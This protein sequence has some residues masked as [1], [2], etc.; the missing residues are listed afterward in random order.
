MRRSNKG[1]YDQ[2]EKSERM[3]KTMW[4][5]D[6]RAYPTPE[7]TSQRV[8]YSSKDLIPN[9]SLLPPFPL[10]K[11]KIYLHPSCADW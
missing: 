6:W 4:D 5:Q 11:G 8:N 1:I 3:L 7:K 2:S 10:L 9:P